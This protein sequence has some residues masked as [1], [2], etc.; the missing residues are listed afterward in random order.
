M[1]DR[2]APDRGAQPRRNARQADGVP[3]DHQ[4]RHPTAVQSPRELDR[5]M[6]DAVEAR[7]I[8]DRLYGRSQ[9]SALEE[10]D[11]VVGRP[12]ASVATRIVV[13]R[14]RERMAFIE[15]NWD[16][17]GSFVR[18][19]ATTS[20]PLCGAQ[21]D[22]RGPVGER[23]RLRRRR[24][25]RPRRRHRAR[26]GWGPGVGRRARRRALR[27]P[28]LRDE[29]LPS[30][31]C[32]TVHHLDLPARGGP[33]ARDECRWRCGP[34]RA[35]TKGYI[36]YMRTDSTTLSDTAMQAARTMISGATQGL[37]PR[38]APPLRHEVEGAQ[39][40]H[41]AIRPAGDTFRLPAEVA[42]EVPQSEARAYE[43][44]W[45]RVV[46][47]QMTD[48][49]GETVTLKLGA[50]AHDGR[51]VEF[52]ASARDRSYGLP[53]GL[54]GD[55]GSGSRQRGR[56]RR[57]SPPLVEET[58]PSCRPA[59]VR[60]AHHVPPGHGGRCQTP[61]GTRR[62]ASVDLRINHRH[63]PGSRLRLEEG[64]GACAVVPASRWST[65][66]RATSPTSSTTPSPPRWRTTSTRSPPVPRR[67]SRG[68]AASISVRVKAASRA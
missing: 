19:R 60:R 68:S 48:R 29:A 42:Q 9:P 45:Q 59:R 49:T 32:R 33:Q 62:G 35:S 64:F 41:E 18:R 52:A 3:R 39:E 17:K 44:I 38:R 47:S 5:K 65:S 22:R 14:E 66:W 25:P 54:R 58:L 28:R 61:R 15:A 12:C 20:A 37:P 4:G 8:L 6:V 55:Q 30:S 43:L 2:L 11:A 24:P 51:D 16:V 31:S 1:G 10:G 53:R 7:R 40:A 50:T 56:C 23:S 36:T 57:T 34:C 67:P 27:G 46:A 26:R 63:H 13:E 21:H